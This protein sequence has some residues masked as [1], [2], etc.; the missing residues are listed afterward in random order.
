MLTVAE[1]LQLNEMQGAEL[2]AGMDGIHKP[3]SWVHN[4]GV[5]DAHNWINGGELVLTT[6][7]N[8]PDNLPEQVDFI[9]A[10]ANKGIAGLAIAVGRYIERI[11]E[12]W[13]AT[14]NAHHL[15]LIAIPYKSRFID[16]A[17]AV[18]ERIAQESVALVRRALHINQVLSRLVLDGG[19]LADLANVLA[20]L[21]GQSIS[22]ETDRF[23]ALASA[24]IAEIDEARRY[25]LEH[26]RT[27]PLLIQT[28]EDMGTLSTI[29][30][31][32]RPVQL[33]KLPQVGLDMERILAPIVV[34]GE[35]YGY[36]W[37]IADGSPL[38]D[39]DRLALESGA[40]VAALMMLHREAV[41][42]AEAS[43][44]GSLLNQLIEGD[45]ERESLLTDQAI[46]YG[47]DLNKPYT[48]LVMD[49]LTH[50]NASPVRLYRRVN[51]LASERNWQAVVS[52]FAG[53]VVMLLSTQKDPLEAAEFIHQRLERNDLRIGVSAIHQMPG[54]VAG[55]YAEC[56]ETLRITSRLG[57]ERRTICF[58]ELGYI[59]TIYHAGA[60]SLRGNVHAASLRLLR[61]ETQAD[62]FRTLEVYLD[63]GGN[64]VATAEVLHIHRSTLNYRL[65][66][67]GQITHANLSDPITRLN[68]QVTLKQLRLFE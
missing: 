12:E 57:D 22:I 26:G 35:I 42:T 65:Q 18:N 32:L 40:T 5:P 2:V 38:S 23:D 62:L 43:L 20:D 7:I 16:I 10:L 46:R 49:V 52:Q 61:E 48:M 28:L 53:Q 19:G 44:K 39:I 11:P 54:S 47:I 41:Q 13:C 6:A 8:M 66:R 64:G 56:L 37:I 31:T 14:A 29:R 34:H 55:A 15:P 67:I 3:I 30:E 25:T 60:G 1:A 33:P 51:R 68:L 63:L 21:I 4:S 58:D 9:Q 45:P 36:M 17:R 24:N 27:N 59:H 50:E